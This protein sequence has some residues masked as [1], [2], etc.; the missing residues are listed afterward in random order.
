MC[1]CGVILCPSASPSLSQLP[2]QY[3]VGSFVLWW[4]VCDVLPCFEPGAVV[5]TSQGPKPLKP[6]AKMNPSFI[7]L[8]GMA[9]RESCL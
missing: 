1:I 6:S 7:P 8:R 3:V 9:D 5:F 2:V 4:V